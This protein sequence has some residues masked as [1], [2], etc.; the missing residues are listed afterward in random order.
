MEKAALLAKVI[1][2]TQQLYPQVVAYRRHLHQNPE[3]SFVEYQ[4][5]A[6][7]KSQL[8][9]MDIPFEEVLTTGVVAW[10]EGKVSQSTKAIV[11]R[12]DIDAL[13]IKEEN[14]LDFSSQADGVMHACGHDFHTA[15]LLGVA[16]ILKS[17]V[18]E[19]SGRVLLLFQPAEERIPGGAKGVIDS[20]ILDQL[21]GNNISAVFGL[22]VSPQLNTGQ[23]GVC[24]GRFMASSDEIYLK[25]KGKGGHAAEPHRAIDPIMVAVQLLS[26]LQQVVSRKSNPATPSVLTFGKIV[27]NG[28]ANVIPDEVSLEGTFRTMDETWR[29]EALQHIKLMVKQSTQM[30][31][32]QAELEIRN[33]YPVLLNNEALATWFKEQMGLYF[34]KEKVQEIPQWMAAEDFAYYSHRYPAL[35]FLV[36]IKNEQQRLQY[37][38]HN[39]KFDLDEQAFLGAMQAMALSA[40]TFLGGNN[41]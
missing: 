41:E 2:K 21:G 13:P 27:G 29:A 12:A 14:K 7:I 34:G 8:Q 10:V 35:F 3:L 22:H 37:G 26:A 5:S 25:I 9:L 19:F 38:L 18:H 4:T 16:H 39:A 1:E 24:A 32:A 15:N 36:G 11:L 17:L 23:I 33:G 30:L 6:Y 20:G 31:G 40:L 28:A